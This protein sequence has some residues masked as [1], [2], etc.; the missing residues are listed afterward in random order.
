LLGVTYKADVPDTRASPAEIM[1]AWWRAH[2]PHLEVR[3][4]DPIASTW[5]HAPLVPLAHA[6]DGADAVVLAT[7]H[8]AWAELPP[9]ILA[10]R[11]VPWVFDFY[12]VLRQHL[13]SQPDLMYVGPGVPGDA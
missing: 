2:A 13:S 11:R 1:L 6:L 7:P 4:H 9:V 5:P 10:A 12:G 8:G 3:A